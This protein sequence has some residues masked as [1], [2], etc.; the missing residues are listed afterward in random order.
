MAE[1]CPAPYHRTTLTDDADGCPATTPSSS[2]GRASA[3]NSSK[4]L[5]DPAEADRVLQM[6]QDASS[7][8]SPPS[9]STPFRE[10]AKFHRGQRSDVG[11]SFQHPLAATV[12]QA[13]PAI[14]PPLG[15]TRCGPHRRRLRSISTTSQPG[16]LTASTSSIP[17]PTGAQ[18]APHSMVPVTGR[19][20]GR[21][22]P[23]AAEGID[24]WWLDPQI[25][26]GK[27]LFVDPPTGQVA[28]LPQRPEPE[29]HSSDGTWSSLLLSLMPIPPMPPVPQWI[30]PWTSQLGDMLLPILSRSSVGLSL[31]PESDEARPPTTPAKPATSAL[32]TKVYDQHVTPTTIPAILITPP[33]HPGVRPR[34]ALPPRQHNDSK[35]SWLTVPKV[36]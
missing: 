10:D 32:E 31:W 1:I 29:P 17:E 35:G 12:A 22:V 8:V 36:V 24:D 18:S 30:N 9:S 15:P 19:V 13:H 11:Q 21:R 6:I 4:G 27:E 3:S 7:S 2:Y 34:D 33:D 14:L 25:R 16:V 20:F 26:R 23:A 5:L 28:Y